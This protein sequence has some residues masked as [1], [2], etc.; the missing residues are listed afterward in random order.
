MCE[1][2]ENKGTLGEDCLG[3]ILEGNGMCV[4]RLTHV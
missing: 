4:I 1:F 3:V 2:G